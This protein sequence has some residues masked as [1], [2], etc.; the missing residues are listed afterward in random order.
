MLEVPAAS[1]SKFALWMFCHRTSLAP[2]SQRSPSSSAPFTVIVNQSELAGVMP[3][4][5]DASSVRF[6][7]VAVESKMSDTACAI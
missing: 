7:S 6:A 1:L 2:S 4:M 5:I 3:D